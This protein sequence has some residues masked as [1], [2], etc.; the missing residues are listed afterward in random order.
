MQHHDQTPDAGAPRLPR[1]E[2]LL[3]MLEELYGGFAEAEEALS[4]I[5]KGEVDAFLVSTDEGEK[6]YTLKTAEHPYRVLIEQMREGA[7]ILS[8]EGT[9][10]YGNASFARLLNLPLEQVMGESIFAFIPSDG[11]EEFRRMMA[12]DDPAGSSGESTLRVQ[13]EAAVPAYLSLKPLQM[14]GLQAFSL[15]AMDLT[16]QKQAEEAQK[17][18]NCELEVR[19]VTLE[20]QN[21][22]LREAYA[23]LEATEEKY[24]DLYEFAPIGYFTLDPKGEILETN[25]AGA[26]LLGRERGRLIG[27]RFGFFVEPDH[28][29]A[30]NEFLTRVMESGK[31]EACEVRVLQWDMLTHREGESAW[32]LLEGRRAAEDGGR[33]RLR[34]AA[35][36][37]S[38]QV[39]A[40]ERALGESEE[41]YR[42]LFENSLDGIL[43]T[44]PDGTILAANPAACRMLGRTEEEIRQSGRS[45]IVDTEDRRLRLALEEGARTGRAYSE[46]TFIRKDGSRFDAEI[47][48]AFYM[49]RDGRI[50]TSMI[51]RDITVRKR[52][53]KELKH[54]REL[55]QGIVDTIPVL[56]TIYDPDLRSFRFN[57]ELRRVLGWSEEDA[58]DDDFMARIYPDPEDRAQAAEFMQSLEPGWREFRSTAKDGSTVEISWANILLSDGTQV[59]VG[60]DV[61]ERKR[62][63]E[64]IRRRTDELIRQTQHLEAA[65]NEANLYLDI[66]THDIRNANNVSFMYAELIVDLA[67]GNLSAYAERLHESIRQSTEILNNVA[68]IRRIQQDPGTLV[69]VNL[70]AVIREEAGNVPGVLVRYDGRRVEVRADGLLP[71][72]LANLLGNAAKFGGPGVE[73]AIHVEERDGEVLVSVED[74]G[75]GVPDEVKESIFQRFERGRAAGKGEGL[76]LFICRTVVARYGGRIWADDRVPGQ[77]MEGAAFRFT[78]PKVV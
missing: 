47:S 52:M 53:E 30:F 33:R 67:D 22:Q 54:K 24:S 15:V 72:V 32:V 63:E 49:S 13:G 39:R 61:R 25:L 17:R 28:L 55:F 56:I 38:R 71:A 40:A 43:L 70:D 75:P 7:A 2:E 21:L 42:L 50:Q 45:G 57:A 44:E 36:D 41:K 29:Q 64:A 60:I 26:A 20:A 69:P 18:A 34:V 31:T 23:A 19:Q 78:L 77:P 68:T 76:G 11:E 1:E 35:T 73:I 12:A 59:G 65:E 51:V 4:A 37:I 10:L 3:P 48:S 14:D 27:A 58:A 16:E 66:M 6:V 8:P 62:A 46:L 74:T 9:I 5:R